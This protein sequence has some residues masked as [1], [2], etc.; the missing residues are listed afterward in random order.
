MKI[1]KNQENQNIVKKLYLEILFR[2][3][4]DE[5]LRHFSKKLEKKKISEEGIREILL[6]SEERK[7]VE[8][9]KIVE[10]IRNM[11]LEIL[12]REPDEAA[13]H[14]YSSKLKEKILTPI[15][16]KEELRTSD[17]FMKI[18][19][20]K[21]K[22]KNE[23]KN[24]KNENIFFIIGIGRSGTTFL[25]ELLFSCY[26][27][28]HS[29]S[30]NSKSEEDIGFFCNLKESKYDEEN[31]SCWYPIRKNKDFLFL[32]Q[33]I[34]D[35]WTD[36][37][38][39]EKTPDSVF[40]LKEMRE[41]FEKSNFIFLER[42]PYSIVLSQLNLF[43]DNDLSER[44]WHIKNLIS[45]KEDLD[46]EFEEYWAKFTLRGIQ[47]M[48]NE[49]DNFHNKII[50]RYEDILN[51]FENEFLKFHKWGVK[52]GNYT[53]KIL[54]RPSSSSTKNVYKIK[55]ITNEKALEYINEACKI[56]KY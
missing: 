22:N 37:F 55:D 11:Y 24:I 2:E 5:G 49:R 43:Q 45:K 48:V 34:T 35:N 54:K 7:V 1:N 41:C 56:L 28:K 6:E 29:S 38:F 10:I 42:N 21:N 15:K 39:I 52:E 14:N 33:F 18:V 9:K 20:H 8:H 36:E 44:K 46:L 31:F 4:D 40:S 17:E 25:Q 26:K 23:I 3:A 12:E 50:F 51:N 13:L 53:K 16:M 47:E 19:A 32:N 27:N 30:T